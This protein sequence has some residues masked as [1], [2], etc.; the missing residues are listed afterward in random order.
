MSPELF[1]E[2]VPEVK[3][4]G[5]PFMGA[6]AVIVRSVKLAAEVLQQG[7]LAV[8]R[9]GAAVAAPFPAELGVGGWLF[10]EQAA[11]LPWHG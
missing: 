11:D 8:R 5:L 1:Y 9:L 7:G 10:V 4:P 2:L 3:I 6:Y